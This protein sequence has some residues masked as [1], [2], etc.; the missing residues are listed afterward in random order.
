MRAIVNH[1]DKDDALSWMNYAPVPFPAE[2]RRLRQIVGSR[3]I[4]DE[5]AQFGIRPLTSVDLDPLRHPEDPSRPY[6]VK[7]ADIVDR[8]RLVDTFS[9]LKFFWDEARGGPVRDMTDSDGFDGAME[10]LLRLPTDCGFDLRSDILPTAWPLPGEPQ[11]FMIPQPIDLRVSTRDALETQWDKLSGLLTGPGRARRLWLRGQ[12]REFQLPRSIE[13]TRRFYG[14]DFLP[15][16]L[17]SLGRFAIDNPDLVSFGHAWAG[18]GHAWKK[19]FM[20]WMM[21]ANG[22]WFEHDPKALPELIRILESGDDQEF[23]GLLCELQMGGAIPNALGIDWPDEAD[24]LRQW[25]FAFMKRREFGVTLQQYGYRTSLL[26]VTAS[27]EVALYFTQAAFDGKKVA[28]QSS[29][30]GRLIYVFAE[31]Q[32]DIA[33]HHGRQLAWGSDGWTGDLPPR[34]FRQDAGFIL[35]AHSRAQNYYSTWVVARI[36]IDGPDVVSALEDGDLFPDRDEDLL[37][38]TLSRSRPAPEGLY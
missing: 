14:A 35:G 34:L 16:L 18:P 21:R 1:S 8:R 4:A 2:R 29:A 7:D 20:I 27:L 28:K 38:D 37:L 15:S 25:F 11:P 17:P 22:H 5:L 36:W 3:K 13:W 9:G 31:G 32:G 10:C 19:P 23:V 24:D 33:F 30:Q 12:R 26:D 6:Q